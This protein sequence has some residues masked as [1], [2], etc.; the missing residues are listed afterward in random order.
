MP[1]L[2][3]ADFIALGWF[4]ICALGYSYLTR[5]GPLSRTGI[6]PAIQ[7]QRLRWMQTMAV[8]EMRM[9]DTQILDNLSRGN[10]FFASTAILVLGGLAAL[11]G[12]SEQAQALLEKLPFLHKSSE[13]VWQLKVMFSMALF[14]LAFFKFAWAFRLSH[15]TAIL[16]GATPVAST[17]TE[18]ECLRFSQAAARLAG[19][20][21]EHANAGLRAYYFG[22]AGFGWLV[23]PAVL[24]LAATWVVA[25]LYRREYHSRALAIMSGT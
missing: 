6:M 5:V 4:A 18:A 2:T 21:G 7:K 3:T 22:L 11:F 17:E 1:D 16:I 20:A 10:A 19:G 8:R 9:I 24:A 25:V 14:I 13:V 15:Y 23:H 12:A